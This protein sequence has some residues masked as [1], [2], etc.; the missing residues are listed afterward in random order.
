MGRLRQVDILSWSAGL[1]Q[2]YFT[3]GFGVRFAWFQID[4]ATYGKEVGTASAPKQDRR[5]MFELALDF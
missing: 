2:R 5:Y 1:N 4:L 3:A